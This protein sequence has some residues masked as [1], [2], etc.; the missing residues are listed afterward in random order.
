MPALPADPSL[1]SDVSNVVTEYPA[2]ETASRSA[3]TAPF[4]VWSKARFNGLGGEAS[5]GPASI[6]PIR[7][8]NALGEEASVGPGSTRAILPSA[9]FDDVR[10]LSGAGSAAASR[11]GTAVTVLSPASS[12]A[13]ASAIVVPGAASGRAAHVADGTAIATDSKSSG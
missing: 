1:G 4:E 11:P 12:S 10:S 6:R 5:A 7:P 2:R 3:R 8:P 9:P 13:A